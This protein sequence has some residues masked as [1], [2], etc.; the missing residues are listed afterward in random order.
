[1]DRA[2]R[3]GKDMVTTLASVE[4]A[5]NLTIEEETVVRERL[6][7]MGEAEEK[8]QATDRA[9]EDKIKVISRIIQVDRHRAMRSCCLSML[10]RL[11][12]H[13]S[14]YGPLG[15]GNNLGDITFVWHR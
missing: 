10:P 2:A 11:Y 5:G 7:E 1:M 12:P 15:L 4:Q 14:R 13:P 3:E 6:G 9:I 8:E